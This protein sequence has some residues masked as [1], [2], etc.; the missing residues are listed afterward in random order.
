VLNAFSLLGQ[1]ADASLDSY[2]VI[3]V[4]GIVYISCVISSGNTC[5]GINVLKSTDNELFEVIGNIPGVCGNSNNPI[6]YEFEDRAP[7]LNAINYYK[8]EFGGLGF[9]SVL[10]VNVRTFSENQ[11][12]VEPNPVQ[13]SATVLFDNPNKEQVQ[14]YFYGSTGKLLKKEIVNAEHLDFN[15]ESWGKGIYFVRVLFTDPNKNQYGSFFKY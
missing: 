2:S 10:N 14:I 15:T 3:E 5:N 4:D 9:S 12:Q 7:Q 6:R 13:S 11:I 8:I 1:N